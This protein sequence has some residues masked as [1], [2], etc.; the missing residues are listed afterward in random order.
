MK[1]IRPV[2][3][4]YRLLIPLGIIT[5]LCLWT[6]YK[7]LFQTQQHFGITFNYYLSTKHYISF[8]VVVLNWLIF[9]VYRPA[10]KFIFGLTLTLGFFNLLEYTIG[11]QRVRPELYAG[12]HEVGFAFQ[13]ISLYMILLTY[14]IS[15][16]TVNQIVLKRFRLSPEKTSKL[17]QEEVEKDTAKFLQIYSS[18]SN[19][20]LAS[21]LEKPEYTEG[22][23]KAARQILDDRLEKGNV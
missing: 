15:F 8:G 19:D 11:T 12:D 18:Y 4:K 1:E 20:S 10:F 9:F 3:I 6:I 22:A 14:A 2:W 23:R 13:P 16:R 17:K 7:Y 21:I 5:L